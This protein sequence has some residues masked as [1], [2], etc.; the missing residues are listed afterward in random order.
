VNKKI[1]SKS[2]EV[3]FKSFPQD[4]EPAAQPRD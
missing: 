4:V 2:T 1:T 3:I